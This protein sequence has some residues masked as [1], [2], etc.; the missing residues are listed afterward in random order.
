M[1]ISG[2]TNTGLF[3]VNTGIWYIGNMEAGETVTLTVAFRA[4][5]AGEA[6]NY[7]EVNSSTP[8]PNPDNNKDSST[9]VIVDP[10]VPPVVPGEPSEPSEPS[11]PTMHATGNPIVMVLL[12]LL[13]IVGVTLRRKD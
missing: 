13:A 12:A 4:L 2:D 7:A 1:L 9:V 10:D 8:D 11:T 6:V 5:S 3:D